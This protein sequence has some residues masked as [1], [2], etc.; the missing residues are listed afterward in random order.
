MFEGALEGL[1]I[2]SNLVEPVADIILILRSTFGE[3]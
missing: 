3:G 1:T 2:L